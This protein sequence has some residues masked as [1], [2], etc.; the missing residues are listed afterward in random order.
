MISEALRIILPPR[1]AFEGFRVVRAHPWSVVL[2]VGCYLVALILLGLLIAATIGRAGLSGL[3]VRFDAAFSQPERIPEF[4]LHFG[5]IPAGLLL[6]ALL[7]GVTLCAAIYR[8]VLS[9]GEFHVGYLRFG[10]DELRLFVISLLTPLLAPGL[11]FAV[12]WP[13]AD[14][15]FHASGLVGVLGF[16]ALIGIAVVTVW[17]SV[18]LMF[19]GPMTLDRGEHSIEDSWRLTRGRFRG[20][21]RL[22]AWSILLGV[23]VYIVGTT[24]FSLLLGV[25]TPPTGERG[26]SALLLISLFLGLLFAPVLSTLSMVVMAA[27]AAAAYRDLSKGALAAPE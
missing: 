25:L 12:A 1:A 5:W 7:F 6:L 14:K 17:I 13:I 27:P 2:W 8:A 19:V 16:F 10:E 20:L 22:C 18:R 4:I 23:L 3:S 26:F 15:A 21:L 24:L 9:P 11:A